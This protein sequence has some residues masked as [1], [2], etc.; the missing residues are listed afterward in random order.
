MK[1]E[2]KPLVCVE[3]WHT[4]DPAELWFHL[5]DARNWTLWKQLAVDV[6][7][8]K[9]WAF[10]LVGLGPLAAG[11]VLPRPSA[12]FG[13]LFGI[14]VFAVY[15]HMLWRVASGVR[16]EVLVFGLVYAFD[17]RHPL[18]PNAL[19]GELAHGDER[20]Q[21]RVTALIPEWVVKA[22]AASDGSMRFLVAH[23]PE[24]EFSQVIGIRLDEAG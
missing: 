8:W 17:R 7:S 10:W 16:H 3:G 21:E 22:Y 9:P 15:L 1:G 18:L 12:T 24:A 6:K 14:L 5:H 11:A 4:D 19:A 13:S 2:A 23:A 20:L